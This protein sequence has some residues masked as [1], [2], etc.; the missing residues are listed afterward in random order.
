MAKE[1]V[2]PPFKN[3]RQRASETS[4][5]TLN[6]RPTRRSPEAA[7][8][9]AHSTLVPWSP[10]FNRGQRHADIRFHPPLTLG[11][12]T[13][14]NT[15]TETSCFDKLREM[16]PATLLSRPISPR[17]GAIG[18]LEVCVGY[19][20]ATKT[21]RALATAYAR[22]C[23][24][25]SRSPLQAAQSVLLLHARHS[26]RARQ[27]QTQANLVLP[28]SQGLISPRLRETLN[29]AKQCKPRPHTPGRY[30][31]NMDTLAIRGCRGGK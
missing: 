10:R 16:P 7:S 17:S 13:C 23:S 3:R 19:T 27:G 25:S 20:T 14:R 29:A 4:T 22:P 12:H 6:T 15:N 1:H 28:Y 26:S 8:A 30:G 9:I 21:H 11:P 24:R 18:R 5:C 2:H 31:K